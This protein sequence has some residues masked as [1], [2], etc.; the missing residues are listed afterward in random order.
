MKKSCQEFIA[1]GDG[2]NIPRQT[3]KKVATK[4]C[5]I[6][7]HKADATESLWMGFWAVC[8]KKIVIEH[9]YGRGRIGLKM[10][11]WSLFET[12]APKKNSRKLF[13]RKVVNIL[14][15]PPPLF[16]CNTG[17]RH[18]QNLLFEMQARLYKNATH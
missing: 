10:Q 13:G 18:D 7:K 8:E 17:D 16:E 5:Q 9:F 15:S 4:I 2:A 11:D 1:D 6:E 3:E 12:T 14:P